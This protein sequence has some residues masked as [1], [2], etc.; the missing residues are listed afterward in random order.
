MKKKKK[1]GKEVTK[2]IIYKK[3]GRY[4][5][6][7]KM[8]LNKILRLRILCITKLFHNFDFSKGDQLDFL[9]IGQNLMLK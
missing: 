2:R 7:G 4:R 1:I 5:Q 6:I 9:K 3:W 8:G